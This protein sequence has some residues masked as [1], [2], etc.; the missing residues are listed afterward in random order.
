[1][2]AILVNHLDSDIP[3]SSGDIQYPAFEPFQP[4]D[5]HFSP[6][7]VLPQAEKMVEKVVGRG[8]VVEEASNRI[9]M[10]EIGFHL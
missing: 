1:M 5:C 10:E 9:R 8:N 6:I 3:C 4:P 7:K 2:M